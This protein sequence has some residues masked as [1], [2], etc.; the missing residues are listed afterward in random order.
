MNI[1]DQAAAY[2]TH[3]KY[4]HT[5]LSLLEHYVHTETVIAWWWNHLL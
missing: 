2:K 1:A 5:A 3:T 4:T